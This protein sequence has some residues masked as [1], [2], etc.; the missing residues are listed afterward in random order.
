MGRCESR[1]SCFEPC[2]NLERY[3]YRSRGKVAHAMSS[4]QDEPIL[5]M[6]VVAANSIRGPGSWQYLR[7]V[8]ELHSVVSNFNRAYHVIFRRVLRLHANSQVVLADT[9]AAGDSPD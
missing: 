1:N 9:V 2:R 5:A 3:G 8:N 7:I 4:D 6:A